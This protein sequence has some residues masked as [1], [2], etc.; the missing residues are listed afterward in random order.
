[1]FSKLDAVLNQ[2]T[3]DV[4][5]LDHNLAL[6]TEHLELLQLKSKDVKPLRDYIFHKQG[7]QCFI[8]GCR[9]ATQMTLDHQHKRKFDDY[10]EG[11]GQVRGTLCRA[12]NSVEGKFI[13]SCKRYKINDPN[14]FLKNLLLYYNRG[15]YNVI[16]HTEKQQLPKVSKK[17]YKS[18]SGNTFK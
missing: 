18:T 8:C 15:T 17:Q 9:D 13:N 2:K 1:M 3:L 14:L 10:Q 5:N 4:T 6:G 11:R 7:K 12:C 16:H